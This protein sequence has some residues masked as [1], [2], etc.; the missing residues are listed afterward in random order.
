MFGSWNCLSLIEQ[1]RQA[2]GGH[3]YSSYAG[4]AALYQ[5][6]AVQ[7]SWEGD[8]TIMMMQTGRYLIHC[9]R[10]AKNGIRQPTSVGYLNDVEMTKKRISPAQTAQ[11]IVKLDDLLKAYD[12]I[13][14]HLVSDVGEQHV[15]LTAHRTEAD[16]AFELCGIALSSP[17]AP[18]HPL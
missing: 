17:F 14:A 1:C 7:C 8:N 3:G 4:L 5:D 9:Y 6:F 12:C 11:D 10:E 16:E 2:L 13:C 15:A 18:P